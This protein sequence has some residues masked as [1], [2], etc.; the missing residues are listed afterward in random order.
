MVIDYHP[1]ARFK[2]SAQRA[3]INA[4]ITRT[5]QIDF[6]QPNGKVHV[7]TD[8]SYSK[9]QQRL[10]YAAVIKMNTPDDKLVLFDSKFA[11]RMPSCI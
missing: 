11:S 9:K 1:L 10:G 2:R 7:Y 8:G 3:F 5:H 6:E 4:G